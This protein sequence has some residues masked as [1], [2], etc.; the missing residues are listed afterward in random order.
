MANDYT[1]ISA[2]ETASGLNA[3]ELHTFFAICLIT[4]LFLAYVWAVRKGFSG[5]Q[6]DGDIFGYLILIL[7][8]AAVVIVVIMFFVY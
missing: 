4:G 8:G 5:F 3:I 1:P 2:F 6:M 7:K